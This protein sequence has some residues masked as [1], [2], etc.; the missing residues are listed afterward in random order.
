M[1]LLELR[2]S[3]IASEPHLETVETG[4]TEDSDVI[5]SFKANATLPIKSMIV[6]FEPIQEGEGDPSPDNIR[7]ITGLNRLTVKRCGKNLFDEQTTTI[8]SRTTS[9]A[10]WSPSTTAKS[11]AIKVS[12][13]TT[14][15]I[16]Y[17]NAPDNNIIFRGGTIEVD[18]STIGNSIIQFTQFITPSKSTNNYFIVTTGKQDVWIVIQANSNVFS[19]RNAKI[20][21]ELGSITSDYEPYREEEVEVE[22]PQTVYGGYVDIAKGEL[23]E[24]CKLISFGGTSGWSDGGVYTGHRFNRHLDNAVSNAKG[25][26]DII[27]CNYLKP[28]PN[29]K[30]A[31]VTVYSKHIITVATSGK[32]VYINVDFADTVEEWKAYL[33]D[34]PLTLVYNLETPIHYP[35]PP[36]TIKTLK[37]TNNIYTNANGKSI[38]KYWTH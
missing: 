10:G 18:P 32:L 30:S 3:I 8:Y 11:A 27:A 12:P 35:L 17:N 34:H 1:N 24:T 16:S 20:Q 37:G 9:T 25:N 23:I 38:I 7:P 5:A 31:S 6:N 28:A 4:N 26:T 15:T 21:V 29:G 13:N 14:Y 36:E 2:R 33:T 19:K 22:L